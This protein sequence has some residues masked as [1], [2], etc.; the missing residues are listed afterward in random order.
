MDGQK[1][2]D[3]SAASQDLVNELARPVNKDGF[4]VAVVDFATT[5]KVVNPLEK[6]TTLDGKLAPLQPGGTTNITAGLQDALDI[7]TAAE[8]KVEE[9]VTYLRPVVILFSDG[10]HNEGEDPRGVARRLK[11][12]ADL[13]TI[14]F[15]SDAD[16]AALRALAS[17]PQHFYRCANGREL[18]SFLAAV[19]ATLTATIGAGV[20]A[21]ASLA[22]VQQ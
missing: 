18:R 11:D 15:G 9:G 3:A 17:S 10:Q 19:G 2:A 20:N 16:E 13:V 7:L 4:S 6:A 14:A 8:S 1:A 21:S 12:K 5:S 22:N